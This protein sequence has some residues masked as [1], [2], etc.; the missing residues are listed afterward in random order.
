MNR[1]RLPLV[2]SLCLM[3]LMGLLTA[4][5]G[6]PFDIKTPP[7]FVELDS[8]GPSY[9]YRAMTPEGV[10]VAVRVVPAEDKGDLDFWT[11]AVTLRMR[12]NQGYALFGTVDVASRDGT[13]GKELRL[14]HDENGKPYIY[15]VTLFMAQ[16]RLF[17][18]EAGGSKADMDR[19]QPSVEWVKKSFKVRCSTLVSPV[20]ASS[21]CNRW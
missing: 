8:Q 12:Q 15:D 4:A 1:P 21:T 13:K 14:G 2:F 5:C 9:E 3:G 7:G 10:V 6:R 20:L 19:Y 17:I 18:M 11:R 16:D